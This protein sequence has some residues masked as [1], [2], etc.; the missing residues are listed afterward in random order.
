MLNLQVYNFRDI[1]S[2]CQ[3]MW[4]DFPV[5]QV[6]FSAFVVFKTFNHV[7]RAYLKMCI[8]IVKCLDFLIGC[9]FYK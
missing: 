5:V 3:R 8:S 7:D 2:H 1:E 6:F 4:R 9:W